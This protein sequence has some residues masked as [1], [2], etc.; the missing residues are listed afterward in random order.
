MGLS[1]L[2]IGFVVGSAAVGFLIG[3]TIL[4]KKGQQFNN[5]KMLIYSATVSVIGLS[6][7]PI[8]G[9]LGTVYGIVAASIIHGMGEGV[10]G[11]YAATIRQL[12]SP[13]Q[14]LGRVN[15]VQRTLNWGAWA[16]GSF[17]SAFLVS[18]VGLQTTLF[19][20]GFGTSLCLIVLLRRGISK[21]TNLEYSGS[22]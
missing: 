10:F 19:I 2:E 3:N 7:I 22:I 1:E 21:G 18:I 6:L 12:A 15:A 9:Y 5:T 8:M 16:L 11:P 4:V 13:G 20:G 14:M 17:A